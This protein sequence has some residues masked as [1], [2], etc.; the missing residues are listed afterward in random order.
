MKRKITKVLSLV[1]ML[2]VA[3]SLMAC[4]S[5][6][7]SSNLKEI[8]AEELFEK[9]SEASKDAKGI[10][11]TGTM[12][13]KIAS[14][15][16][17]VSFSIDYDSKTNNEPLESYVKA[18]ATVNM[19]GQEQEMEMELYEVTA[20]DGSIDVYMN[21]LGQWMYQSMDTS[22]ADVD[23]AEIE[24]ALEMIQ[25][26]DFETVSEYFDKMEV[27]TNKNNYNLVVELTSAKLIEKLEASAFASALEDI[28]TTEI[29]DVTIKLSLTVDGKTFL[30]KAMTINFDMGSFEVEG[31]EM[32]I[33]D[34]VLDFKVN[35]Y[36]SVEITVPDEALEAKDSNASVSDYFGA[37]DDYSYDYSY[38]DEDWSYEEEEET[39]EEE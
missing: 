4:G 33:S 6:S 16:Q 17:E 26:I 24:A 36:D 3:M 14:D 5:K 38:D 30:P 7:S 28:D 2:V 8:S 39:T 32:Q 13:A 34:V 27:K 31:T 11:M 29:P 9:V 12:G 35:S 15:G 18:N 19:L 21:I 1:M 37:S 25:S 23:T 20:E 22:D 10:S